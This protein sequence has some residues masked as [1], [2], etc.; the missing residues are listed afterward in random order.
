MEQGIKEV[1]DE[2]GYTIRFAK[3]SDIAD[4][5]LFF[6]QHWKENH[7]LANDRAFFEYEF[8]RGEEVCFVLLLNGSNDIEGTLG[9]IPYGGEQRDV[10]TVMWKALYNGRMF[11]GV[12]MLYYLMENGRCRHIFTSGMN[13]STRNIYKYLGFETGDLQHFYMLNEEC[14]NRIAYIADRTEL[15]TDYRESSVRITLQR[16]TD[17][18]QFLADYFPERREEKIH[19]SPEYMVHR[20]FENPK[21][22]YLVYQL[23]REG[24]KTHS[25][26]IAR[27]QKQDESVVLR[28]I[29]FVGDEELLA[30]AGTQ[31]RQLMKANHYEYTDMYVFGIADDILYRAGFSRKAKDSANIIPDYFSPFCRKNVN[32][33]IFWEKGIKP[34]I[35]KGDGDQ[36]RP[37]A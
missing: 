22:Q 1:L 4:I 6:K 7:I 20:Y 29:D 19:K 11:A 32:I 3:K 25:F 5:M 10:F 37:S 15:N 31:L 13:E 36:D 17:K 35:M 34:I 2:T 16:V 33:G 9:Y 18:E 12:G 24:E 26:L 23:W 28:L 30:Y 27:E 14:E 21:Y 8:C